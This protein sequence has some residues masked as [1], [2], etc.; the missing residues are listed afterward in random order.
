MISNCVNLKMAEHTFYESDVHDQ[1]YFPM[2]TVLK[3]DTEIVCWRK[4]QVYIVL[5]IKLI[6]CWI[7]YSTISKPKVFRDE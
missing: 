2:L 4:M 3:A 5:T 6:I 7:H 1:V